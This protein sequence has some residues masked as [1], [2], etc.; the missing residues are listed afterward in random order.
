MSVRR[1]YVVRCRDYRSSK[2]G[3][4]VPFHRMGSPGSLASLS[5]GARRMP[6]DAP[7]RTFF[8]FCCF[9]VVVVPFSFR[10]D[11]DWNEPHYKSI[12]WFG[13]CVQCGWLRC[14]SK[15]H[16]Q[17]S[18]LD[19]HI[20]YCTPIPTSYNRTHQ[21]LNVNL[22]HLRNISQ[23]KQQSQIYFWDESFQHNYKPFAIFASKSIFMIKK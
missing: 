8:F 16:H 9:I 21:L 19:A 2:N 6:V 10:T 20:L 4:S 22:D 17:R 12:L 3:R 14:S 23:V 11:D 18:T 5:V 13:D 15:S 1:K 7:A